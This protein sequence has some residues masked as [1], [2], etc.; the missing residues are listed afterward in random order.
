VSDAPIRLPGKGLY[1]VF[2]SPSEIVQ[3]L[4]KFYVTETLKQIYK[5]VGSLD[6]VGNP[7][8]LVSAFV[9][10]VRDLFV[11][12]SMA[13]WKSPTDPSRVGL[14]VAQGTLSC[15]SYSASGFFGVLAK[16]S[17]RAGQ[18]VAVLSLDADF[19]E[20]HRNHVVVE[21]TNLNRDWK[22][23]GVQKVERMLTRPLIDII[24]GI[25]G[26]ISGIVISP[27][28][29]YK[30]KGNLGL[31]KGVAAGGIGLIAKPTVGIL[32]AFTHFSSSIHDIAKS[33]NIL[34]KR[35]QPAIKL[36]MPYVFGM[37]SI[38]AP[39]DPVSARAAHLLKRFP[40]RESRHDSASTAPET[41]VHAE[42]LPS[43]GIETYAIATTSRIIIVRVK[44]EASGT[45]ASSLRWEITFSKESTVSSEV[46]DHG[47]N[48]VA[49]SLLKRQA[50]SNDVGSPDEADPQ[51]GAR[52]AA[53]S[54][55]STLLPSLEERIP[56]AATDAEY[57][58]EYDHG[59]ER[60]GEG[61]PLRNTIV[62]EYQYRR[63]L[64][65]L[66]NVISCIQGNFDAVIRDPSLG[67]PGSSTEGYTSFG[68]FYFQRNL[69]SDN[70][71][72]GSWLQR[73]DNLPWISQSEFVAAQEMTPSEQKLYI[74]SL[75]KGWT[76]DDVVG[77]PSVSPNVTAEGALTFC[78]HDK[79]ISALD[80]ADRHWLP[81]IQDEGSNDEDVHADERSKEQ[82]S[83]SRY[84]TARQ[85]ELFQDNSASSATSEPLRD[86]DHLPE[87]PDVIQQQPAPQQLVQIDMHAFQ[88]PKYQT[89]TGALSHSHDSDLSH[90]SFHTAVGEIRSDF[91]MRDSHSATLQEQ[92]HGFPLTRVQSS[93][94]APARIF[95]LNKE[96]ATGPSP[97]PPYA[98]L[99]DTPETGVRSSFIQEREQEHEQQP[100]PR[101]DSQGVDRMERMER[102]LERLLIFSSEQ[103]L[104][105]SL[106][107]PELR[108]DEVATLRQEVAELRAQLQQSGGGVTPAEV[109]SLRNEIASL[110]AQLGIPAVADLKS[111][112]EPAIQQ[113]D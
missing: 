53:S 73:L 111:D 109:A 26:G 27:V 40:I 96:Q 69:D 33:V 81:T 89:Q 83:M 57:D 102:L 64:T 31:A 39:F 46:T 3:S 95:H 45:L 51:L 85:L 66:H 62:A 28:K 76:Y 7:T 38:L 13:F 56:F 104:G 59:T 108:I 23:R 63:Q 9:S 1:H 17:A 50:D 92:E 91:R 71:R 75:R 77:E 5:I 88:S 58:D 29:G 44:K 67:R 14:G 110:R 74:A 55:R 79:L 43:I 61:K 6:F 94:S 54:L 65:R 72:E 15:V 34:D 98:G 107:H 42:L 4:R 20:W 86:S 93:T 100:A 78:T 106:Q 19:R 70:A 24:I 60:D 8:M 113:I 68:M 10:G 90:Q 2:E 21:A 105:Q 99:R 101:Q 18:G 80:L 49:L 82:T 97:Q 112:S 22:R 84:A 37:M 11:T 41:M 48:G 12:P 103:A 32:D 36:R 25:T 30:Q 47:H 16:V 52:S 35:L 87:A